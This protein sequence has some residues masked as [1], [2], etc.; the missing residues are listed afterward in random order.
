[1]A[2]SVQPDLAALREYDGLGRVVEVTP[3]GGSGTA[4]AVRTSLGGRLV[5]KPALRVADV[6]LQS[7]CASLLA[8]A[9][10]R[11]ARILPC[12]SGALVTTSGYYL[13][14]LL[15]GAAA[16]RPDPAQVDAAMRHIGL[17]HSVLARLPGG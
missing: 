16:L 2:P 4:L 8:G 13:Q 15:P 6:D 10:I 9:G 17:F 11:Q 7:R 14:E 3:L 12:A 5:L 1:M